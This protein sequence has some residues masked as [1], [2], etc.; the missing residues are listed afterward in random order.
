MGGDEAGDFRVGDVARAGE[1]VDAGG[2]VFQQRRR[3]RRSPS[4]SASARASCRGSRGPARRRAAPRSSRRSARMLAETTLAS[5]RIAAGAPRCMWS[6]RTVFDARLLPAVFA[7]RTWRRIGRHVRRFAVEHLVGRQEQ[8]VD[9][10]RDQPL[11]Q[12]QGLRH[13]D[14]GR[15]CGIGGAVGEPRDRGED[16]G[17]AVC[18]PAAPSRRAVRRDR[19]RAGRPT[20]DRAAGSSPRPACPCAVR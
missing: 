11:D 18:P 12:D 19:A 1:L 7:D 6:R 15:A 5:R 16:A 10:A 13:V 17:R 2:A 3:W 20:R 8:H 4:R 9:A 14:V